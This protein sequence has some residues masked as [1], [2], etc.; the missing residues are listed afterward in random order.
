MQCEQIQ[1]NGGKILFFPFGVESDLSIRMVVF[2]DPDFLGAFDSI[3]EV[4][5]R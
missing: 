2:G 3:L 4:A 5:M 1:E